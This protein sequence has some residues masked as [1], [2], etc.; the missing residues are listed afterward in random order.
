MVNNMVIWSFDF[1]FRL[2]VVYSFIGNPMYKI[3]NSQEIQL[4][5]HLVSDLR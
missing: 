2:K 4:S 3:C 1:F 5:G